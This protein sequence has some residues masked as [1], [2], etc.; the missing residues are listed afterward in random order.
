MPD[1]GYE[2]VYALVGGWREWKKARFPT[3]SKHYLPDRRLLRKP[4]D[5]C[6]FPDMTLAM[7]SA[8]RLIRNDTDASR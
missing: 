3:E 6:F 1:I 2:N 7:L 8:R 4:F 5:K